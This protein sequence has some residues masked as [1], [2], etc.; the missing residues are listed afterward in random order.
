VYSGTGPT[1]KGKTVT[2]TVRV[3][4]GAK[5]V[6]V[7]VKATNKTKTEQAW[8]DVKIAE[9]T[10]TSMFSNFYGEI[11]LEKRGNKLTLLVNKYNK[12]RSQDPKLTPIRSTK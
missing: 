3:K 6:K 11:I 1:K 10:T 4:L 12:S 9:S 2:K 8:S 7:K 5:T